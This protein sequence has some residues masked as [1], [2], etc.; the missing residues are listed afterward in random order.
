M[1]LIRNVIVET[2]KAQFPGMATVVPY[3][4]RRFG[5]QEE[6]GVSYVAPAL[7]VCAVDMF[8]APR[9]F[10]P[11]EMQLQFSIA[12]IVKAAK[13]TERDEQG[14]TL[15]QKVGQLV[16]RNCWGYQK[17]INLTPAKIDGI[18]KNEQRNVDG[19]PTGISYW[20]VNFHHF[21]NFDFLLKGK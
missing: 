7:F 9:E 19:E 14:W 11:W 21:A 6:G 16:Y 10:D 1:I 15:A 3:V 8:E 17:Q 2:L 20:L 4:G 18:T 12:V 5:D 13:A